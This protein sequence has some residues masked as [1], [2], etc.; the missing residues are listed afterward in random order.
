MQCW[1]SLGALAFSLCVVAAARAEE[2]APAQ[3]ELLKEA[4]PAALEHYERGREHFR[5]GHYREAIV[6]LKAALALDPSSANLLYNVA[7]T[8]ELA[9]D[10]R[11]AIEYYDKYV[12]ALPAS[13]REER[14][15]TKVTLHR[16]EGRLKE[17]PAA[18]TAPTPAARGF[19]RADVLFWSLLGGGAASLAGGAITG[20]VALQ[21]EHDVKNFVAGKDGSLA[22]R[23]KL[24]DQTHSFALASDIMM[25]A[26][27]ALVIA[28][29]LLFSLRA[30][31]EH[32]TDATSPQ[33]GIATDGRS[34]VATLR[35]RF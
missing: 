28:A 9:G 2:P 1:A 24:I 16:L 31:V 18:A 25:G 12:A 27:A 33:A 30:P 23:N 5:S 20:V 7:Y 21:R 35:G 13:E 6:E 3:S 26:G 17:H 14:E 32:P 29:G 8:S 15:K 34:L 4:P 19:G 22:R 10:I 11:G